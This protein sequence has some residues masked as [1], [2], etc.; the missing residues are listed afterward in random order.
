MAHTDTER[1]ATA[2]GTER[3]AERGDALPP[4]E[5]C[6]F[7]VDAPLASE[8]LLR[9]RREVAIRHNGAIYRLR[10]TRLGKLILTK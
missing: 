9:G 1:P 2:P 5:Q 7:G 3:G 4:P 6:A 8:H 10:A